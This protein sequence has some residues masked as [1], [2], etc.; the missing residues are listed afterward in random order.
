VYDD[1]GYY[2]PGEVAARNETETIKQT[3]SIVQPG[4][5]S[6]RRTAHAREDRSDEGRNKCS[7]KHEA[8]LADVGKL[9]ASWQAG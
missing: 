7:R 1:E 9:F 2:V 8:M 6:L 4:P 5:S 3:L